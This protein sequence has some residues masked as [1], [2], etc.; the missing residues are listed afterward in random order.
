MRIDDGSTAATFGTPSWAKAVSVQATQA[1]V[2]VSF[3]WPTAYRGSPRR[4]NAPTQWLV[5]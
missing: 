3:M 4:G 2:R 1:P 5:G